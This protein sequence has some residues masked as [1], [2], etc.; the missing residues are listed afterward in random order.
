[1]IKKATVDLDSA[2]LSCL[3]SYYSSPHSPDSSPICFLLTI[4]LCQVHSH[5]K[6]LQCAVSSVHAE[7]SPEE[8]NVVGSF[9]LI[10]EMSAQMSPLWSG[11]SW[12]FN[13]K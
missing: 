2:N 12:Y 6:A 8:F 11:L 5:L 1:M 4:Q 7:F 10:T 3:I 9:L 13:L